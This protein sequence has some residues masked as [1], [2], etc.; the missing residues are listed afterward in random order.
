MPFI[1]H[2]NIELYYE[3]QGKGI[4]IVF[5]NG[6]GN[7][8][9]DWYDLGYVDI[10]KDDYQLVLIDG[11]GFGKSDKPHDPNLYT[12]DLA[13]SDTIALMDYLQIEK[14]IAF[15]NSMGG[16]MVYALMHYHPERFNCFIAAGSH[17]YSGDNDLLVEFKKWLQQGIQ[18]T[19]DQIETLFAPFPG[20]L[21][22]RYLKN[23]PEAMLAKYALPQ[24]DLSDTLRK[25]QTPVLLYA[26]SEDPVVPKMQ[27]AAKLLKDGELQLMPGFDHGQAYWRGDLAGS[28]IKDFLKRKGF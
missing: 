16:R 28:L 25:V 18:Y 10:L 27:E 4:P 22:D 13:T 19:V 9:E 14:A 7:S 26:G 2:Q 3:V 23:D 1:T 24:L 20:N 21:R 6:Y 5:H 12:E 8:L 11:R 17:P 15:G